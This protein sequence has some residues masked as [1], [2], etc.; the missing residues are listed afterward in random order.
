[1]IRPAFTLSPQE[2][3][4]MSVVSKS[5]IKL[6]LSNPQKYLISTNGGLKQLPKSITKEIQEK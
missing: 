5:L 1:M 2:Q 3:E 4:I 6:I